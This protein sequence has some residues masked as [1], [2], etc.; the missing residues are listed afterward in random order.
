M[1]L[2]DFKTDLEYSLEENDNKLFENFYRKIFGEQL[3]KIEEVND[4]ELQFK[5]VDKIL[6]FKSGKKIMIDEKKRRKDWNDIAIEIYSNMEKKT[7]GW[8]FK[9]FP[10]YFLYV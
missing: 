4:K 2:N 1:K 3:I 6:H 9:P 10:D 5:G 8:S 7:L